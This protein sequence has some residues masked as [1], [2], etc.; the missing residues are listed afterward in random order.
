[1]DIEVLPT[2]Q[3]VEGW[4]LLKLSSDDEDD[5]WEVISKDVHKDM[6]PTG[7]K[8]KDLKGP[9]RG[10]AFHHQKTNLLAAGGY[11]DKLKIYHID[12]ESGGYEIPLKDNS[13]NLFLQWNPWYPAL[14]AATSDD[15]LTSIFDVRDR[16]PVTS[17]KHGPRKQVQWKP[18]VVYA[19][20]LSSESSPIEIYDFRIPMLPT[21]TFGSAEGFRSISWSNST[22]SS[23]L[24]TDMNGALDIWN[25]NNKESADSAYCFSLRKS[26]DLEARWCQAEDVAVIASTSAVTLCKLKPPWKG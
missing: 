8:L 10:L 12:R 9:V 22:H 13:Q 18:D 14:L 4:E 3:N 6:H 25:L 2:D 23:I 24:T 1:M 21:H 20:A 5:D 11:G 19:L 7:H 15:G 26:G 16:K 17:L